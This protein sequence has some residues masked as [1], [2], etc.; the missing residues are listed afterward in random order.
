MRKM[1][2]LLITVVS[3]GIVNWIITFLFNASFIDI[4]IPFGIVAIFIIYIF[5]NKSGTK[6]RQMDVQIQGQTGIKMDF[7]H[8]VNSVSFV[9]IGSLIYFLLTLVVS[10]FIYREYFFN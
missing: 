5:T 1:I 8:R 6:S 9:F 2:T 7:T 10:F 3:L 4:A